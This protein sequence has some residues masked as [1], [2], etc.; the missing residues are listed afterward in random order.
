LL[1]MM[2]LAVSNYGGAGFHVVPAR[3]KKDQSGGFKSLILA[4]LII[5]ENGCLF[6]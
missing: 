1:L 2:I 4:G 6:R 5:I 3:G